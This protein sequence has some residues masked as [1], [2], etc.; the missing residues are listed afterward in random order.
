MLPGTPRKWE[1]GKEMEGQCGFSADVPWD[2]HYLSPHW[3]HLGVYSLGLDPLLYTNFFCCCSDMR[4]SHMLWAAWLAARAFRHV[5]HGCL[6][7]TLH[8]FKR[9]EH[10]N[11]HCAC[12]PVKGIEAGAWKQYPF[13]FC[14]TW[15]RECPCLRFR[16]RSDCKQQ[17]KLECSDCPAVKGGTAG[18]YK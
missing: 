16:W 15:T 8:K 6:F 10:R 1:R 12:P 5:D 4:Y 9:D 18:A 13:V 14:L 7:S 2:E 17:E 11:S 3:H